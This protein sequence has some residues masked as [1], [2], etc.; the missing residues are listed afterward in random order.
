MRWGAALVRVS[1]PSSAGGRMFWAAAP[2][3]V[4]PRATAM[5]QSATFPPCVTDDSFKRRLRA[6]VWC[7]PNMVP[8]TLRI[9]PNLDKKKAPGPNS[10]SGRSCLQFAL[11]RFG[12]C[13][14]FY[15]CTTVTARRFCDQ[16][17]MSLQ[18][19]TGRSLPKDCEVMRCWLT[20]L[21]TR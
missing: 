10:G 3:R 9:K 13:G 18:I 5:A 15:Y 11:D 2:G 19:A 14:P 16:Q 4:I 8:M 17:E 1:P 21:E 7:G 12:P 20:P 6:H